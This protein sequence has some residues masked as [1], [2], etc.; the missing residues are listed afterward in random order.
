MDA[1]RAHA[2]E[3]ADLATVQALITALHEQLATSQ[4]DVVSQRHQLDVLCRRVFGKKSERVDPRQLQL[5]LA[6]LA[7]EPGLVT[8]P[9][10]MDSGETPV[11]AM[12]AGAR[13]VA[14]R[15]PRTS[16]VVAWRSTCPGQRAARNGHA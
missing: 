8:A 1:T 6:Q 3:I 10:E 12:G 16:R 13:R 5:A 9:V 4:R 11:R 15:S 2:P 7:N 14:G